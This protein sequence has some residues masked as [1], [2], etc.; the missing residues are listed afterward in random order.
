MNRITIHGS[1]L[2]SNAL[3]FTEFPVIS[4]ST[5]FS[6][7]QGILLSDIDTSAFPNEVQLFLEK[8]NRF[9]Q[10]F[11][12]AYPSLS[13]GQTSLHYQNMS[14]TGIIVQLIPIHSDGKEQYICILISEQHETWYLVFDHNSAL[15]AVYKVPWISFGNCVIPLDYPDHFID[16][17]IEMNTTSGYFQSIVCK[18]QPNG[19]GFLQQELPGS[20]NSEVIRYSTKDTPFSQLFHPH[21]KDIFAHET[22]VISFSPIEEPIPIVFQKTSKSQPGLPL[23]NSFNVDYPFPF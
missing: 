17:C 16:L 23:F 4:I 1:S 20:F 14:I 19:L 3:R 9:I 6:Q 21:H 13:S 18:F 12:K 15:E 8:R 11:Q 2:C 5:N 10:D 7:D 22:N